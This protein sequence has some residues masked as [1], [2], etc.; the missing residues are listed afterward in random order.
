MPPLNIRLR[1]SSAAAWNCSFFC[2]FLNP[3]KTFG[4][5]WQQNC[6]RHSV[7][8]ATPALIWVPLFHRYGW[9]Q[10]NF[11]GKSGSSFQSTELNAFKRKIQMETAA[12]SIG[13]KC[14]ISFK[15]DDLIA[16]LN[17]FSQPASH[18]SSFY[19]FSSFLASFAFLCQYH[20]QIKAL[21]IVVRCNYTKKCVTCR[22]IRNHT[23]PFL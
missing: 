8:L 3:V 20:S 13:L 6:S 4:A 5:S 23:N 21:H 18:P 9:G 12:L 1:H 10:Y 14:M 7:H 2:F 19:L 11:S 17:P 15:W 22:I 16:S